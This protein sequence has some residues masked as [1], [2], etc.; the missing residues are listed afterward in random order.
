MSAEFNLIGNQ[1]PSFFIHFK[2]NL[3]DFSVKK[4]SFFEVSEGFGRQIQ[5]CCFVRGEFP[6]QRI[7][8]R[9]CVSSKRG[10]VKGGNRDDQGS[11]KGSEISAKTVL[12][13][14]QY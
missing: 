1:N 6:G 5:R 2:P 12:W 8:Q 13:C 9:K 10:G 11:V 14:W 4:I 7:V 3:D